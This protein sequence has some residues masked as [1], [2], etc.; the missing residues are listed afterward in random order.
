MSVIE[1]KPAAGD[2]KVRKALTPKEAV[3]ELFA[4]T[5]RLLEYYNHCFAVPRCRHKVAINSRRGWEVP[6]GTKFP[7]VFYDRRGELVV[8]DSQSKLLMFLEKHSRT[9][10]VLL[11]E[12]TRSAKFAWLEFEA[13]KPP[14]LIGAK[15]SRVYKADKDML[16]AV[17]RVNNL[18]FGDGIERFRLQFAVDSDNRFKLMGGVIVGY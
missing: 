10:K 17:E 11:F 16:R 4:D 7:V 2:K 5:E 9:N 8:A 1:K 13:R 6:E 12:V 14:R 18:F 3:H 15:R